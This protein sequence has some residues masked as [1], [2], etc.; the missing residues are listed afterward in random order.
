MGDY[1][2]VTL[3]SSF[4]LVFCSFCFF[5]TMGFHTIFNLL[6]F[7]ALSNDHAKSKTMPK[8]PTPK[9]RLSVNAETVPADRFGIHSRRSKT[10]DRFVNAPKAFPRWNKNDPKLG[11]RS[12][13]AP[14]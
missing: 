14:K 10:L 9:G 13:L 5:S 7:I 4:V 2:K 8:K 11:I 3:V 1:F 6:G 12:I